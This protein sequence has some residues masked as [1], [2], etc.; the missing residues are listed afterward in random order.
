VCEYYPPG[1]VIGLFKENV[2]SQI[3]GIKNGDSQDV[4]GV[5]CGSTARWNKWYIGAAV[6]LLGLVLL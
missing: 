2:Q 6:G 5:A 4:V 1:N 3:K